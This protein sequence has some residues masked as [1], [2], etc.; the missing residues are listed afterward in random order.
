MDLAKT[1]TLKGNNNILAP[2]ELSSYLRSLANDVDNGVQTKETVQ[3]ICDIFN[4]FDDPDPDISRYLFLGWWI[5][6][7][8]RNYK[9]DTSNIDPSVC[10]YC[11]QNLK[12]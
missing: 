3:N 6:H 4:S 5:D 9:E 1:F 2:E 7:T 8:M 11:L 12:K 10:P